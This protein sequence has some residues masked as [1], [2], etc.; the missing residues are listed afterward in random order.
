MP[1]WPSHRGTLAD[2]GSTWTVTGEGRQAI[3]LP[4]ADGRGVAADGPMV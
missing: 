1:S 3:A 2:G 4:L